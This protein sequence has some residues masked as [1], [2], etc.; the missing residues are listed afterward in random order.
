M[1]TEVD[2]QYP[3]LSSAAQIQ[4]EIAR[5]LVTVPEWKAKVWVQELT[6]RQLDEYRQPMYK[7]EGSSFKMSLE[8]S[9]LRLLALALVDGNSNR[10][11]PN[12][13]RGIKELGVLPASGTERL[14][15][16]AR[17]LSGLSSD[18]SGTAGGAAGN[19]GSEPTDDSTSDSPAI[20]DAPSESS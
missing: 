13:D 15:S 9:N 20:S 18:D 3:V 12:T 19:S 14:G 17:R 7:T 11:F 6:G 4:V 5:E 1:S 16:V 8:N 2:E 10:L